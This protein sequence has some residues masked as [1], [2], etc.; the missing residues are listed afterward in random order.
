MVYLILI[1]L[2]QS[3]EFCPHAVWNSGK[4]CKSTS[5]CK[6]IVFSVIMNLVVC[7]FPRV[8][9][10]YHISLHQC[11]DILVLYCFGDHLSVADR[12]PLL[13][14]SVGS[15]R[16]FRFGWRSLSFTIQ[17]CTSHHYQSNTRQRSFKSYSMV[18]R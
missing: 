9:F 15:I 3:K 2:C 16:R 1:H 10:C 13:F 8:I 18:K 14:S 12:F 6:L 5:S 17:D 11:Y 4:W 7:L